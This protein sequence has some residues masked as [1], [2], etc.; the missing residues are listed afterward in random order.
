MIPLTIEEIAQAIGAKFDGGG[1]PDVGL[2]CT[3]TGVA[4][5][6]RVVKAGD[7]FV[8]IAGPNHDGHAYVDDAI[9]AGAVAAVVR[10][11]YRQ[12]FAT[13]G[14]TLL[15]EVDDTLAALG[16]L[17]RFHRRQLAAD[18]IA[19]TGSNGKTTTKEMIVHV[20]SGRRQGRGS[21]KSYNNA[22]GVP[23]TLL[24]AV[25]SDAFLV[26]EVGT[27]APGEID[28]LA[29]LVEPEVAVITGVGPVHLERLG[30]LEGVAREKL[31]L[32]RHVR[33]GGCAVVNTDSEYV[34]G[35]LHEMT[36]KHARP[37]WCLPKEVK[38]VTVGR[39]PDAD[40]RLTDVRTTLAPDGD[41]VIEPRV[42]FVVNERFEYRLRVLGAHNA[43]NALAAI[44]V[45]RRFHLEHAEI[46]ER[47]ATFTLPSM[48][49][50]RRVIPWK[51]GSQA[52]RLEL[53]VDAYNANPESVSAAIEVL[54]E[55]PRRPNGR[56]V[57]VL[58]DMRELGPRT[59]EF[60]E[61]AGRL[62]AAAEGID[63]F[64]AIGSQ[65]HRMA[66]GAR[67][68][69]GRPASRG[70]LEVHALPDTATAV[71]RAGR[72]FRAEDVVLVKGSRAMEL[73]RLVEA[74]ERSGRGRDR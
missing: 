32:L 43:L 39:Q 10:S 45:G 52:G 64:I 29:R 46:A 40:L 54:R 59:G 28:A 25:A 36:R 66:E 20:L 55:Y 48:R 44:A 30:D 3:A 8:A 7:L 72:L 60:H 57:M 56:R 42:E 1:R 11:G 19:V 34:R 70:R 74:V 21:I 16:R 47:L 5:D 62:V 13:D 4:T 37:D 35:C 6:S 2:L 63:A 26:A 67:Q 71:R 65:A 9:R 15:L 18:V 50:E 33:P 73:E 51:N 61:E 14:R 68:A 12:P 58:G 17:G 41:G 24:A 23:L 38:L 27:N 31:S 22:V 69:R 49:L 53:I